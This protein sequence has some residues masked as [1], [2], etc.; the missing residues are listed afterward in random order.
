M[1]GPNKVKKSQTKKEQAKQERRQRKAADR[2]VQDLAALNNQGMPHHH[3]HPH[4]QHFY[5]DTQIPTSAGPIYG[6]RQP[7]S[8]PDPRGRDDA[9]MSD[10][11]R[12]LLLAYDA[13]SGKPLTRQACTSTA[14]LSAIGQGRASTWA[15]S[16][17]WGT[18]ARARRA[19]M[20]AHDGSTHVL[21][22]PPG[23][24]GQGRAGG[25]RRTV[26][27]PRLRRRTG[28]LGLAAQPASG[29]VVSA[30][31][32]SPAGQN[33]PIAPDQRRAKVEEGSGGD[34]SGD[35][36]NDDDGYPSVRSRYAD[37]NMHANLPTQPHAHRQ[38]PRCQHPKHEL[39]VLVA[40]KGQIAKHEAM[41]VPVNDF[42][43][44]RQ[45]AQRI[46]YVCD[47]LGLNQAIADKREALADLVSA[48]AAL[49]AVRPAPSEETDREWFERDSLNFQ[50]IRAGGKSNP[51]LRQGPLF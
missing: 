3:V 50:R 5:H 31:I 35:H 9:E 17:V 16:V 42:D 20:I 51:K 12:S 13:S 11:N 8:P 21:R 40:L 7:F 23:D 33:S 25:F 28:R 48:Y 49:G 18:W 41:S 30:R 45:L 32:L 47:T 10:M 19:T 43:D 46:D 22:Q 24:P 14:S 26:S 4:H 39:E 37:P 1:R 34:G 27:A 6:M 15:L 2:H 44:A 38:Q 36:D 29:D